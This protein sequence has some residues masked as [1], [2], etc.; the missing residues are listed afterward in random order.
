MKNEHVRD[1]NMELL[2]IIAMLLVMVVHADFRAL[3]I[4]VFEEVQ[5]NPFSSSFR[6]LTESFSIISVNVF[7]LL[8][9]WY[10]IKFKLDRLWEFLFQVFFFSIFLFVVYSLVNPEECLTLSGGASI[11]LLKQW[12][13]WF[14]KAYMGLYLFAP[15]INSFIENASKK[16]VQIFLISF[17]LF[18][19]V[20]AWISPNGAA[21]FQT[22]Y[23][24]ISFIGLY[25]LARYIRL[26][27]SPIWR[28]AYYWDLMIY[29]IIALFTT[30]VVLILV[31]C[32]I[33]L[34]GHLY[35]YTSPLVIISAIYFFLFFTKIQLKSRF[36][37]WIACSCF[38]VYLLHSNRFGAATF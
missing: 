17:Y 32:N 14:V 8:S 16:Q 9:G 22:G 13:Y 4:P 33:S 11:L 5:T 30:F 1:S 3:G 12:D 23:S 15:V 38:A 20:Y 34:V 31:Y 24:S 10:G 7:V 36:V 37:N 29:I 25:M 21:F 35:N 6:F 27:P 26:Y 2:R 28:L 18:Q 19:T